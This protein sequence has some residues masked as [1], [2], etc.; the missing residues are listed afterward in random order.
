MP[1]VVLQRAFEGDLLLMRS[2]MSIIPV[3]KTLS[4]NIIFDAANRSMAVSKQHMTHIAQT[5]F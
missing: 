2:F 1:T 3:A 4:P 5:V